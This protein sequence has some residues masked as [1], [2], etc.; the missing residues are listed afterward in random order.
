[1]PK[2]VISTSLRAMPATPAA[3]YLAGIGASGSCP[4]MAGGTGAADAADGG[5]GEAADVCCEEADICGAALPCGFG[6]RCF[7]AVSVDAG[8]TEL[9]LAPRRRHLERRRRQLERSR[10]QLE[11]SRR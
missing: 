3:L 7:G 6:R 5:F 2:S 11:R 4:L 10:R 9:P 8:S 1:M